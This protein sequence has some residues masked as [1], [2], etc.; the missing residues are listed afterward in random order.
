MS[1]SIPVLSGRF[2]LAGG[3]AAVPTIILAEVADRFAPRTPHLVFNLIPPL[4]VA[5]ALWWLSRRE[6]LI[7]RG[8]RS[9][10]MVSIALAAVASWYLAQRVYIQLHGGFTAE[11]MAGAVGALLLALPLPWMWSSSRRS[12]ILL[13]AAVAAGILGVALAIA[14]RAPF[15]VQLSSHDR[16][17]YVLMPVWQATVFAALAGTRKLL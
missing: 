1:S 12:G 14:I 11:Y 10:G 4:S 13:A 9:L 5:F 3:F 16:W 6:G 2:A 8:S 7:R 17:L 15:H